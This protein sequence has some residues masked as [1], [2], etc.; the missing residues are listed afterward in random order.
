MGTSV[1]RKDS[2]NGTKG[3]AGRRRQRAAYRRAPRRHAHGGHFG[4]Y[5]LA[6]DRA[7]AEFRRHAGPTNCSASTSSAAMVMKE[8]LPKPVYKSL[9]KTIEAGE[10]LDP[11]IADVVAS[12]MKDWA[13][14][15]GPPTTP[16]SSSR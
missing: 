14:E 11:A 12:A 2:L 7:A 15:K 8:R 5:Q 1:L 10:K 3:G 13:I 9:C 16:T 6:A 4:R